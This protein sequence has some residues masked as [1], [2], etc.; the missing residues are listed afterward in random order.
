MLLF[1]WLLYVFRVT[2]AV[3]T[4]WPTSTTFST[5]WSLT[6]C[7]G[8]WSPWPSPSSPSHTTCGTWTLD[9]TASST[10]WPIRRSGW[11]KSWPSV[12]PAVPVGTPS[13]MFVF[14]VWSCVV[15]K[16]LVWWEERHDT[17][18]PFCFQCWH[19]T[20]GLNSEQN[21]ISMT[22]IILSNIIVLRFKHWTAS[23]QLV[24]SHH[25]FQLL[26]PH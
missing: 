11:T 19:S 17:E 1:W 12:P 26:T 22:L 15:K 9:M 16:V 7:C 4:T 18:S 20:S 14:L 3:L 6:S 13:W 23:L 5:P 2:Q 10:G 21:Y 25:S 8:W 24:S